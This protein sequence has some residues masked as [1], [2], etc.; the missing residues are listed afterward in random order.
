MFEKGAGSPSNN[1]VLVSHWYFEEASK[2]LVV[3]RCTI[4]A[5]GTTWGGT[6]N[7]IL[8]W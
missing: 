5:F 4:N 1:L 2:A 3:D 8:V 7:G 6:I